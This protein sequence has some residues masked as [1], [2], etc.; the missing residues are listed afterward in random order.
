M[1]VPK[2]WTIITKFTKIY[3]KQTFKSKNT[4]CFLQLLDLNIYHIFFF[5]T[6]T[7]K[8]SKYIIVKQMKCMIWWRCSSPDYRGLWPR[9]WRPSTASSSS[10]EPS[11][12]SHSWQ[13]SVL[14]R[15]ETVHYICILYKKINCKLT[16]QVL[17]TTRNI[18]IAN[19]AISDLLMS[20]TSIPLTL[21]DILYKYWPL[22]DEMVRD[23]NVN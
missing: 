6:F 21:V 4:N 14:T 3:C 12:T 9:H 20:T 13:R 23:F 18:L 17:L 10:L 19:L 22:G 8:I 7:F 15:L 11:L 16:S 1:S 2:S 5:T